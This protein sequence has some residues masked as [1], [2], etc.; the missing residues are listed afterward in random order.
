[1]K[2]ILT[3]L[4]IVIAVQTLSAQNIKKLK[5]GELQKMIDTTTVPLVVNFWATWCAP[6]IHEIPW[7]E[8]NV[9][10]FADKKVRLV[11]VSIDFPGEYPKGI[12]DFV[13]K[14]RYTSKIIWLNETDSDM[15][16]PKIDKSWDGS[17]P[18]TLMVNNAK[19]YRQFYKQQLPEPKLV[20]EL[21]KLVE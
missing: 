6:C 13:A 7:F 1:M 10:S 20:Q 16:C 9:A 19:H 2:K 18:V 14:N 17:I 3:I 21:Q 15:F 5:I 11:L 8:K 4:F 12:T